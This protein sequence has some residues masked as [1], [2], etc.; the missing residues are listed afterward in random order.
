M[1]WTHVLNTTVRRARKRWECAGDGRLIS[2]PG[3][4]AGCGRVIEPGELHVECFEHAAAYQSG[5]RHSLACA[6]EFLG[7]GWIDDEVDNP[8]QGR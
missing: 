5:T 6:M 3:H 1:T 2:E 7:V 8:D 4:A